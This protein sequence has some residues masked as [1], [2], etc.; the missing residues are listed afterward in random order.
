MSPDRGTT[1]LGQSSRASEM[2]IVSMGDHDGTNV[3]GFDPRLFQ[4]RNRLFHVVI[5]MTVDEQRMAG[6][7][8]HVDIVFRGADANVTYAIDDLSE[9]RR[10]AVCRCDPD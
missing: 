9:L 3:T 6:R 1:P 7:P 2:V 5:I 10:V 4:R 8:D